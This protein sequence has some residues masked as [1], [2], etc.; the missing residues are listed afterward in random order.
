MERDGPR[1]GGRPGE[2]H[3]DAARKAVEELYAKNFRQVLG[4]AVRRTSNAEDAADVAAET[5]AVAW[6]RVDDVPPGPQA[7]LWLYGVARNVLANQRRGELRRGDLARRMAT[8]VRA[9]MP[10]RAVDDGPDRAGIARAWAALAEPERELLGLIAWEGLSRAEAAEVLGC[11][12]GVLRVRLH[13]ARAHFARALDAGDE[14]GRR[15]GP[16][17]GHPRVAPREEWTA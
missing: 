9:M 16:D 11:T 12:R 17:A 10:T 3:G 8:E 1:E 13:R 6:R 4:Y 15:A 5:F 14:L 2:P 7:R